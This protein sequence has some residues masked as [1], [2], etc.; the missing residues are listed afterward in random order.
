MTPLITAHSITKRFGNFTAVDGISFEVHRGSI[1]G[2]LGPNGAGKTTTIKMIYTAFPPDAGELSVFGLS[3][4]THQREIKQRLG[5]V[6]Q[7]DIMEEF[8]TCLDNLRLYANY[9]GVHW[10][11]TRD[12]AL[13][14]LGSLGLSDYANRN[15][16]ALSGGMKRR[17]SIAKGL[18]SDP[19]LLLLDE[20]TIGLDPQARLF[21]WDMIR[22]IRDAGKTILMT[23]HY[24]EEA[25][26][27][28]DHILI[29]DHGRI[30]AQGSPAELIARH[31][32]IDLKDT[33]AEMGRAPNL[34]DVFLKLTGRGMRNE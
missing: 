19:E 4:R 10:G 29:I 26:K 12:L 20:P 22:E 5:V 23:T 32:L 33:G 2:F 7:T 28:C 30:I 16:R 24:M 1:V 15:V 9:Y 17:L 21:L 8:G 27:L 25:E 13:Q 31:I 3:T 18:I 34:E 14:F 6:V 11:K